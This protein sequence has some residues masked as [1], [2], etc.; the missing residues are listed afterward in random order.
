MKKKKINIHEKRVRAFTLIEMLIVLIIISV[1]IMLFAPNLSKQ[2]QTVN[3]TDNAAVVKVVTAQAELYRMNHSGKVSLTILLKNGNI[4]QQQVDA[5]HAYYETAKNKG[6][7][8]E[9]PTD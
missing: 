5:Y 9:I 3:D 4:T 8:P 2:K 7:A 1:L 6:E